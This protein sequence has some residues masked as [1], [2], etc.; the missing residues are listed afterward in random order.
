MPFRGCTLKP[1]AALFDQ[2]SDSLVTGR[3]RHQ[4]VPDSN[5]WR[6][7]WRMV[8]F[9]VWFRPGSVVSSGLAVAPLLMAAAFLSPCA[10]GQSLLL[11]STGGPPTVRGSDLMVLEVKETRTDLPCTVVQSKPVLG[12]DLKFHAGYDISVPL[13]ELAG[14]ENLLTIT[15]R[16]TSEKSPESPVYFTQ[17]IRVPPLDDD[18]KG[19][20]YL[21]GSFDLGEGKYQVDWLMRDRSERV[22]SQSWEVLAELP[23]KDR[24]VELVMKSGSVAASDVE[25]FTD[26]PQDV[27]TSGGPFNV[28]VLVNFAPQ[29]STA[30][31]L[32]P[33]DTSALVSILRQLQRE[34]KIGRFSVVAF[35][36]QEQRVLY[37]Q[38]TADRIDFPAIGK[39]VEGLQLGKVDIAKLQDK[40]SETGFLADLIQKEVSTSD[41]VD[42]VI[43]AGPKVML[44]HN[45]PDETLR[46]VGTP[47]YPVFY[48][49]YNLFPQANPWRDAI[50][51][52]VKFF[53]GQEYTISRPRDLWYA[54][55]Q[56]VS[57]I[58]QSKTE[59]PVAVSAFR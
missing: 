12:F 26:E 22:C 31:A 25:V 18:A 29:N 37:R 4:T 36:L 41:R 15:F 58:G 17:K 21:Q 44:E 14:Q 52:A 23:S 49:N 9:G 55:S 8:T 53:K 50:S 28:K 45:V 16:V 33:A 3:A 51:H 32:Q 46:T 56:I 24:S 48:M 20:A 57:R 10:Q 39:A 30:A 42:A 11:S 35:N 7:V 38:T 1:D 27:H 40:N 13:N 5:F 54:V 47:T 6:V 19:D 2:Y 34:P 43:F 59:H